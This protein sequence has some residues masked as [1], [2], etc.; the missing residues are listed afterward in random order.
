A[1]TGSFTRSWT[2]TISLLFSRPDGGRRT[3]IEASE[4]RPNPESPANQ[5]A[6]NRGHRANRGHLRKFVG[7]LSTCAIGQLL[8]AGCAGPATPAPPVRIPHIG[9]ITSDPAPKSLAD[10]PFKQALKQLGYVEGQTI[11][12]D[13]KFVGT[14]GGRAVAVA[15]QDLLDSNLD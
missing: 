4:A 3:L 7:V 9:Y 6:D 15:V 11:V 12:V 1:S 13:Y 14:G 5:L 10:H 2:R 8:A